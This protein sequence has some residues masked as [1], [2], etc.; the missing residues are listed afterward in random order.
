MLTHKIIAP[1]TVTISIQC[2]AF[3]ANGIGIQ[4]PCVE[5]RLKWSTQS[6]KIPGRRRR[7]RIVLKSNASQINGDAIERIV[8]QRKV[9]HRH[10]DIDIEHHRERIP[11]I[12]PQQRIPFVD[13]RRN[14][15]RGSCGNGLQ[16]KR[17]DV[18]ATSE[19]AC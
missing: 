19:D 1:N 17:T 12:R 3:A 15:G 8:R 18:H 13:R 4:P 11:P 9:F 14:N 7:G 2:Q 6:G 16:L 5:S 10:V